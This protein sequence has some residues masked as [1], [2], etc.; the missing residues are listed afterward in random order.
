MLKYSLMRVQSATRAPKN[1]VATDDLAELPHPPITIPGGTAAN[2][3]E[4]TDRTAGGSIEVTRFQG[5]LLTRQIKY[6]E[7]A[8]TSGYSRQH[9]LRIRKGM[10]DPTRRCIKALVDACRRLTGKKVKASDLFDLGEG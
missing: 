6:A 7:L 3:S 2:L 9:I 8:R 1:R 10:M 4:G 5:F